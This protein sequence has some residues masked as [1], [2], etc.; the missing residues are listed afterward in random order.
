MGILKH[1]SA[2]PK[3][4]AQ[5]SLA[6][7]HL[8]AT[9][10]RNRDAFVA[11]GGLTHLRQ[12]LIEGSDEAQYNAARTLRHLAL[13]QRAEHRTAALESVEALVGCL[14]VGRKMIGRCLNLSLQNG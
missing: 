11:S 1:P 8:T 6:L 9:S 3:V 2:N 12:L 5:A 13:G 10:Q 14:K 7:K 4:K